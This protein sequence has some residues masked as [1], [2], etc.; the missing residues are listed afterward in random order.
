MCQKRNIQETKLK[1]FNLIEEIINHIR[2]GRKFIY[3]DET[4]FNTFVTPISGYAKKSEKCVYEYKKRTNN[5]SVIAAMT[6]DGILGY[7]S[8]KKELLLK[9]LEHS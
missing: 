8:S 2:V 9:I 7:Q 4:G 5:F 3:I 1:R 6:E